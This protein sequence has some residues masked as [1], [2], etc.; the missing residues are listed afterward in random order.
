MRNH[1]PQRSVVSVLV[2]STVLACLVS[3]AGCQAPQRAPESAAQR[4]QRAAD[5]RAACAKF[6]AELTVQALKRLDVRQAEHGSFDVLVLSG[7]G[8]FGAFGAGFLQGW[9]KASD[10]AMRRPEFD[11]VFGTSTGALLAPLAFIGTEEA[12]QVGVD[13]YSDPPADLVEPNGLIPILPWNESLMKPT[14]LRR[15]LVA[16]LTPERLAELRAG[17]AKDRILG[18]AS[19]NADFGTFRPFDLLGDAA[20]S[21]DAFRQAM[22]ERL[23]A[24]SAIPAAFP[25]VE[26]NGSLYVD[27]GA[28]ANIWAVRDQSLPGSPLQR[29]LTAHA[30]QTPPKIR[31]WVLVNNQLFP[32]G[33]NAKREW[34][35]LASRGL[36][37]ML[38][39]TMLKDL[40]LTAYAALGVDEKL[41]G[42]VEF[43]FVAIPDDWEPPVKGNFQKPTMQAL[44]NLGRTMGAD[45]NSWRTLIPNIDDVGGFD[46]GEALKP[47]G[48][49]ERAK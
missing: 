36:S 40:R 2:R 44:V 38:R 37:I 4:A 19:T 33:E 22:V 47:T 29:W 45:P 12:L 24:S 9:G 31:I 34:I 20:A 49:G 30:G 25:P 16:Q 15:T 18:C 5:E 21:D 39:S 32:K 8:D 7:G 48:R 28:T 3:F 42:E 10:P 13:L 41:P 35:D 1:A 11:A 17:R 27:G 14:G 26:I 46:A 23:L 6:S 43:R